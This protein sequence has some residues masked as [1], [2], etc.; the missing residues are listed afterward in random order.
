MVDGTKFAGC[1][2]VNKI[3]EIQGSGLVS[4]LVGSTVNIEGIVVGDFQEIG[5]FGGF[6]V[7]E[8]DADVDAD[9]AT[10]E[11]IFVY[12]YSTHVSVGDIVQVTGMVAEYD[13]LTEITNVSQ[14]VVAGSGASIYANAYFPPR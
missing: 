3:H 4:P 11:G 7:Q 12:N 8:E 2:T 1:T 6:H 10:S 5:Q 14:V 13:G 9:P